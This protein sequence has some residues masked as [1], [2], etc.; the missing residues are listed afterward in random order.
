M[1]FPHQIVHPNQEIR[2]RHIGWPFLMIQLSYRVPFLNKN[3]L[4]SLLLIM[5]S[6]LGLLC[7]PS[8]QVLVQVRDSLSRLQYTFD[9]HKT[10]TTLDVNK[11]K[12]HCF[13]LSFPVRI[14]VKRKIWCL[15]KNERLSTMGLRTRSKASKSPSRRSLYHE[16]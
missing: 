12:L 7:L 2:S 9:L 11:T 14:P 6:N 3:N 15:N 1:T 8:F 5:V 13:E 10:K 4:S 16:I